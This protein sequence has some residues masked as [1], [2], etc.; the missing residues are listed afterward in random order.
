MLGTLSLPMSALE[1]CSAIRHGRP[2]LPARLDR[3]LR[4]DEERGLVEVQAGAAWTSLRSCLETSGWNDAGTIAHSVGANLPGPD[5]RPMVAHVEALTLVTTDGDLRRVSRES[6]SGLFAL[7]VGGQGLFGALYSVTLRLASLAA[8]AK[9]ASPAVNLQMPQSGEPFRSI[10]I[11]LP[12]SRVEQYVTQA[13]ETAAQWRIDITGAQVRRTLSEDET[14]L[15]WAREEYAVLTLDLSQRPT[16]G[17]AV[18]G[19]QLC[20]ELL[21]TALALGGS[22]PISCTPDATRA[23]VE[24]CYPR[25]RAFLAEKR[26]L[27]PAERRGN[28][29]YQHYRSLFSREPCRSR[30]IQRAP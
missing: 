26:R 3:V 10:Q 13:R 20:R 9:A 11:L 21:D 28:A 22:F 27:D 16:L 7:T 6:Q 30:W 5:G 24:A 25:L 19:T 18:R 12:P 29:W 2:Y 23:H 1:L 14:F 15:R 8:A 4:L 17:G